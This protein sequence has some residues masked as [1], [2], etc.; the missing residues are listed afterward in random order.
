GAVVG[1]YIGLDGQFM[2]GGFLAAPGGDMV[3]LGALF[4]VTISAPSQSR[5]QANGANSS[6]EVVGFSGQKAFIWRDGAMAPLTGLDA[7]AHDINESGHVVGA[8]GI[9]SLP[10]LTPVP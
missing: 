6:H 3:D 8:L 7:I 5:T 4:P 10:S 1:S 2:L 9:E